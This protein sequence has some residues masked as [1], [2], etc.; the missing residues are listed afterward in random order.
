MVDLFGNHLQNISDENL[1]IPGKCLRKPEVELT[2]IFTDILLLQLMCR[3]QS[4]IEEAYCY[5]KGSKCKEMHDKGIP[6]SEAEQYVSGNR[7][8]ANHNIDDMDLKK[9]KKNSNIIFN[10]MQ[11][12]V[13]P[14]PP[15]R[16][17]TKS[18]LALKIFGK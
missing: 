4:F 18:P 10:D 2:Q 11:C 3:D 16:P 14:R 5:R 9:S 7:I 13:Q 12:G 17:F 1:Q 15:S 6:L 8:T